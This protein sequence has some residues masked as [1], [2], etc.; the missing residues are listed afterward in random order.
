MA[1]DD[2]PPSPPSP[3]PLG[4]PPAWVV[5][6]GVIGGFANL[7]IRKTDPAQATV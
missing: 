6:L 7:A 2:I 3:D 4:P 5:A 1:T